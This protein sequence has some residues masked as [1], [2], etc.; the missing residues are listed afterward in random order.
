MD[1]PV[2]S[3][4]SRSWLDKE[5]RP[6]VLAMVRTAPFGFC[7]LGVDANVEGAYLATCC[8]NWLEQDSLPYRMVRLEDDDPYHCWELLFGVGE[9][10]GELS[11]QTASEILI[12]ENAGLLSAALIRSGNDFILTTLRAT[13]TVCL[14]P[15]LQFEYEQLTTVPSVMGLQIQPFPKVPL[16]LRRNLI[17]H[18][19]QQTFSSYST[20]EQ[21]SF[22]R[23]IEAAIP[24]SLTELVAWIDRTAGMVGNEPSLDLVPLLGRRE[25]IV[26]VIPDSK[27][28]LEAKFA[29]CLELL[30]DI[31]QMFQAWADR[32]LLKPIVDL[33]SPFLTNCERSWFINL[34]TWMS[35]RLGSDGIDPEDNKFLQKLDLLDNDVTGSIAS[36]PFYKTLYRLRTIHQ[37]GILRDGKDNKEKFMDAETWYAKH[38]GKVR[39]SKASWRLLTTALVEE[40]DGAIHRLWEVLEAFQE[41]SLES[42]VHR[43]ML[44]KQRGLLSDDDWREAFRVAIANTD[45]TLETA[46]FFNKH[47]STARVRLS[48]SNPTACTP[49]EAATQVAIQIVVAESRKFPLS[50]L[51]F[52]G[53]TGKAVG[54]AKGYAQ[55]LWKQYPSME[56]EEIKRRTMAWYSALPPSES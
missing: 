50:G 11:K 42:L 32:P 51:D 26:P 29:K 13:S 45:P 17:I 35:C 15:L 37:H 56:T 1:N 44:D 18:L 28:E 22:A 3:R 19:V 38:C 48:Q 54:K 6:Q 20:T 30:L 43:E 5:F 46:A 49:M 41:Q 23:T 36:H 47:L 40:W 14:A 53:L 55:D 16:D 8:A 33:P 34:I 9:L 7:A 4:F 2:L 25:S 52:P 31:D 21:G 27:I 39:P 12:L 10:P 24:T